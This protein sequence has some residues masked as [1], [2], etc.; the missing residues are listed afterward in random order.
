MAKFL[1]NRNNGMVIPYNTID[2][3]KKKFMEIS[4]TRALHLLGKGPD[5]VPEK[6]APRP[7]RIRHIPPATMEKLNRVTVADVEALDAFLD[8]LLA[9]NTDA[10]VENGKNDPG[11]DADEGG[12]ADENEGA[13][14]AA[15]EG[16]EK[17]TGSHLPPPKE[18]DVPSWTGKPLSR[19]SKLEMANYAAVKYGEDE[20]ELLTKTKNE[21]YEAVQKLEDEAA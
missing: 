1:Q 4:E 20:D 19:M 17:E 11:R 15:A 5:E 7:G 8:E 13:E 9:P 12:P 6:V 14:D 2:A 18:H 21:V 10:A 16:T 3:A